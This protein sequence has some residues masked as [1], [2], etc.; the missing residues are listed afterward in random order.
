[1]TTSVI[2]QPVVQPEA[3]VQAPVAPAEQAQTAI[4]QQEAPAPAPEPVFSP[5]KQTSVFDLFNP[6]R[7]PEEKPAPAAAP[8]PDPKTAE[9]KPAAEPGAEAPTGPQSIEQILADLKA[10]HPE[11]PD[12][13]LKR[14][15]DKEYFIQELKAKQS[16]QSKQITELLAR[17]TK[18]EEAPRQTLTE[19]ERQAMGLPAD[20][21]PVAQPVPAP[22]PAPVPV[23]VPQPAPA[24]EPL[25][26]YLRSPEAAYAEFANAVA[27]GE[28]Q[29]ASQIEEQIFGIRMAQMAP[30]IQQ[31]IQAEAQK[32]VEQSVG[33]VLP[34]VRQ[35]VEAQQRENDREAAIS[36]LER[37]GETGI[38][39]LFKPQGEA[40]IEVGGQ[41]FTDNLA[42][43]IVAENPWIRN[44]EVPHADPRTA[45]RLTLISRYRAISQIAKLR[46]ASQPAAAQPAAAPSA[47]VADAAA[48]PASGI[49]PAQAQALVQAGREQAQREEQDRIRAAMNGG[50]VPPA[51]DGQDQ[52]VRL[53][54][55]QASWGS[56]FR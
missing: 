42:N 3:P 48:A 37:S 54:Q 53:T 52:I 9:E 35:S 38:R 39:D 1:M 31:M 43:R 55:R 27:N 56:I 49:A 40:D 13:V 23:P 36:E 18:K 45:Q 47:Q 17:V 50:R 16:E 14:L 26:E 33:D 51:A 10:Q 2:P 46:Q 24:A 22:V 44:I 29:R 6:N 7:K 34:V 5:T 30:Q 41:R 20:G 11:T 21:A 25:P 28:F 19:L 8:E 12:V 4:A 32:I 15:A